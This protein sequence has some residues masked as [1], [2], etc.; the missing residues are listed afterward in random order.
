ME[1]LIGKTVR[2]SCNKEHKGVVREVLQLPDITL[3][4]FG[5]NYTINIK[6]LQVHNPESDTWEDIK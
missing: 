1:N 4:K 6:I 3:V 5:E 2:I